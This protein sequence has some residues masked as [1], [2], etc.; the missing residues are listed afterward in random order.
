GLEPRPRAR[1]LCKIQCGAPGRVGPRLPARRRGHPPLQH[2]RVLRPRLAAFLRNPPRKEKR[3][4]GI[5]HWSL[6]SYWRLV[7]VAPVLLA[8]AA[9]GAAGPDDIPPLRPPR[10]EIPPSLRE[11]GGAAVSAGT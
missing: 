6:V 5:R 10:P 4:N 8:L 3:M 9:F 7:I 1:T 11:T 2:R